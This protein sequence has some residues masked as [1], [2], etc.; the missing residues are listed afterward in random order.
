MQLVFNKHGAIAI[1]RTF[2]MVLIILRVDMVSKKNQI[3]HSLRWLFHHLNHVIPSLRAN[4]HFKTMG[5]TEMWLKDAKGL[6]LFIPPF[7]RNKKAEA[8]RSL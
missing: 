6:A 4:F 7:R 5:I 3:A 2:F 8:K 1:N